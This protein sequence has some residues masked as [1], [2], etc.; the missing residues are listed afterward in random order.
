[1]C[2]EAK[3]AAWARQAISRRR[4]GALG[5]MG[6]TGAL[7]ACTWVAGTG[8]GAAAGIRGRCVSVPLADGIN[9]AYFTHPA[10]GRHP[11]VIVWPDI[12]SLRPAFIQMADRLA[13]EGYAV[14]VLNPYYRDTTAPVFTDFADFVS[15]GGFEKVRPWR[16][17]LTAETIGSDAR[18]A[19]QWL[20]TQPQVDT[21]R[22]IGTQGYCM[23][24]PFTFSSAAA[25]PSRIKG[26]AS[27]HGGGLV[28]D[29]PTSPHL[30]FDDT[31][32]SY[33][34]AISQDDDAEAPTHKTVLRQA[35]EAAGRP[36]VVEV[37]AADH[38]WTVI[39]A[40][41][42]ERAEAERAYIMLLELYR[43]AL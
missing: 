13:G 16:A 1:M 17:K 18:G 11:A 4:F 28:T 42:Y 37:F 40:P 23:G 31:Q 9:D 22:G 38:G 33:L 35:A 15:Q 41:A 2:D 36:E 34:V 8:G 5:A 20:D 43:R 26:V 24:G 25:V 10:E 39:D 32:A 7:A 29:Q 3:L 14:L 12:A 21:D 30:T 6:A 19:V 27:F